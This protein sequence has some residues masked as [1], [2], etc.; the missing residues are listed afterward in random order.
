MDGVADYYSF[1]AFMAVAVGF[2]AY[3]KRS[4]HLQRFLG[5]DF[6]YVE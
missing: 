2:Q 6:I 1:W 4:W 5:R 3:I